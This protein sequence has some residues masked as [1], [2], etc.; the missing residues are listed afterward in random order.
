VEADA[1][2]VAAKIELLQLRL[3]TGR[4]ELVRRADVDALIDGIAGAR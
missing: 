2:H 1:A 3:M 4:H